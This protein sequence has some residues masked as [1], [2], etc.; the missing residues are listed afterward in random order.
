MADT[1]SEREKMLAGDLYRAFDPELEEARNW[2][3]GLVEKFNDTR[4]ADER[5]ALL[6]EL[7]GSYDPECPPMVEPKFR[8]DY[9]KH[10]RVGK[11]FYANFDCTILDC[12]YVDIGDNCFLGPGVQI[13][14]AGHPLEPSIR[15]NYLTGLEFCKPVK[16]GTVDTL[17]DGS[18]CE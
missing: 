9:G 16:L 13:Y 6:K 3:H 2:A 4:S 11:Y 10:I 1:R 12:N 14:T 7:L 17:K 18:D 8:C 5:S 15:G